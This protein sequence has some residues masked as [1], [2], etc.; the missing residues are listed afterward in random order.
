MVPCW[1]VTKHIQLKL[2]TTHQT[3]P[4]L[5]NTVL[6]LLQRFRN[7]AWILGVAPE[8]DFFQTTVP[9]VDCLGLPTQGKALP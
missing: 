8:L 1:G 6:Q 4:E 5:L 9:R 7:W 3:D 2:M